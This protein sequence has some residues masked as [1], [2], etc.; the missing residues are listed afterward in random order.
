[1]K[2]RPRNPKLEIVQ[3]DGISSFRFK[4][5]RLPFF[6]HDWHHHPEMELT[7]ILQG[8]GMRI[9]GDSIEPFREGDLCLLGPHLPHTW[10]SER[11]PDRPVQALVAQF[12]PGF[13]GGSFLQLK[14]MR[15][16]AS[17]FEVAAYGLAVEAEMRDEVTSEIRKAEAA[18][19]GSALRL[20]RLVAALS[21][22]A[23]GRGYR[24]LSRTLFHEQSPR[25][26]DKAINRICSAM[27]RDLADPPSQDRAAREVGMSPSA[28]SRFFKRSTGKTYLEYLN[29]LR[30][31]AACRALLDSDRS[32]ADIALEAGFNNV[33]YFNRLFR[34]MHRM[35]PGRYRKL[36]ALGEI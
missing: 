22:L 25:A 33:S 12:L 2:I 28:F 3:P 36:A 13:L 34:R 31:G 5:E 21:L 8:R 16:L 24:T 1:M 23:S 14:E 19:A 29:G 26:T 20:A 35:T 15:A 32:V 10:I 9:V 6:D 27:Q 18:P 17:L 30:V 4:D 7:L 11:T